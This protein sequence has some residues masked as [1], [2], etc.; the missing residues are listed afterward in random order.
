[1]ILETHPQLSSLS[2]EEKMLLA[3]EL[4]EEAADESARSNKDMVELVGDLYKDYLQHPEQVTSWSEV[5]DRIQ[6]RVRESKGGTD[7]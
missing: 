5:R 1:M 6:N 4:W 2:T 3:S 7:A